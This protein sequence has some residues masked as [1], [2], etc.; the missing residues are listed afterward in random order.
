MI[1]LDKELEKLKN[2]SN[3]IIYSSYKEEGEGEHK[4]IKYIK[5]NSDN[6]HKNVIYG[7]DA[8]LIFLSMSAHLPDKQIYL[9][10][11][12][13]H[14]KN[15]KNEITEDINDKLCYLSI[16]NVIN[17]YHEYIINI[18]NNKDKI[19]D[20]YKLSKDFIILCFMLGNDFI[21]HLPSINIRVDGV[22]YLIEAY[23]KMFESFNQYI[24]DNNKINWDACK[25]ILRY[26]SE[27]EDEY[28][29]KVLPQ[30]KYRMNN[31]KCN[32]TEAYDI[33]LWE[34]DNLKNIKIIDNIKLGY[35]DLDLYKFRYYEY[36]FNSRINQ[37]N[38]INNVCENY[39]NMIQWITKYYFDIE[40]PSWQYCYYFDESP[41][42]SDL[43]NYLENNDIKYNVDY[44]KP[45][46]IKTQLLCVI[47]QYYKDI[48][49]E[50]NVDINKF[51]LK[52]IKYM[53][54][55]EYEIE[56]NKDQY[57]M[58]EVKLPMIDI[59]LLK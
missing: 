55:K 29:K 30:Y 8:D 27:K 23:C 14:L 13:Q 41:F 38:I 42:V 25:L 33:E 26:L 7:L 46:D 52:N 6:T 20:K 9:L 18:L 2:S 4:I 45:I 36:N 50:C 17:T 34:H 43:L 22:D 53:F 49:K 10:R 24:Y 57:W 16:E 48:L 1:K 54:P 44:K 21:P 28:F 11:E 37:K 47:P 56:Y 12:S 31:R 51:K 59:E 5:K 58:C 3:K 32:L 19:I 40:M 39:F 35:G 15:E